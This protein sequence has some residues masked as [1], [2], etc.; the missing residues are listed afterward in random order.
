MNGKSKGNKRALNWALLLYSNKGG[1][2]KQRIIR[3]LLFVQGPI[4]FF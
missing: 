3:H 2:V 4:V 1:G